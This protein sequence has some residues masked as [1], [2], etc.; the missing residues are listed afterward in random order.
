VRYHYLKVLNDQIRCIRAPCPSLQEV[1]IVI[2]AFEEVDVSEE[3]R[4]DYAMTC[5]DGR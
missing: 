1:R 3:D 2:D 5:A 4:K